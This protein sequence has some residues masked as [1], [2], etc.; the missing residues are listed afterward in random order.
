MFKLI[1]SRRLANS[2]AAGTML[3]LAACGQ[4]SDTS[5][6]GE[7]A[8]TSQV[9]AMALPADPVATEVA[10]VRSAAPPPDE[11][12]SPRAAPTAAGKESVAPD[13][14]PPLQS[15]ASPARTA[16]TPVEPAAHD[17]HSDPHAGHDMSPMADHDM[18]GM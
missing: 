9:P 5:S 16:T 14:H 4:T 13:A 18:N 7:A 11:G 12:I 15:K 6:E 8:E 3:A 2:F 1:S 10:E 17:A